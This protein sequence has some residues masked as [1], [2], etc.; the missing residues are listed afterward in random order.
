MHRVSSDDITR[1]NQAFNRI[2]AS[3]NDIVRARRSQTPLA[4]QIASESSAC[5]IQYAL[6]IGGQWFNQVFPEK[7]HRKF[8]P[9]NDKPSFFLFECILA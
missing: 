9:N 6:F 7:L 5:V 4:K 1:M 2:M 8:A 3:M